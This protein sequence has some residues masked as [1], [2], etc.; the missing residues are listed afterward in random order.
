M[1]IAVGDI[2]DMGPRAVWGD[3][4]QIYDHELDMIGVW[5]S[6]TDGKW[7]LTRLEPF[8]PVGETPPE[9][10]R[11]ASQVAELCQSS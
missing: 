7:R 10:L 11:S 2:K 5:N 6:T 4:R 3:Q 8:V 9:V 1:T